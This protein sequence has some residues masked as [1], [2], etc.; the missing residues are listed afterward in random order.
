MSIKGKKALV[1]GASQGLGRVIAIMLAKEGCH[2]V[3]N[4][5]HNP[6]KAEAVAREIRDGGGEAS[7]CVCDISDETA[8]VQMLQNPTFENL[9]RLLRKE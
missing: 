8:V 7:V 6:Q 4:C 2:V 1:T 9:M 3:V 5:A